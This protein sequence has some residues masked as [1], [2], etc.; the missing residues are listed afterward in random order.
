L[1]VRAAK[2]GCDAETAELIVKGISVSEADPSP[3]F[4]ELLGRRAAVALGARGAATARALV[5]SG[6][7][8][9]TIIGLH[10]LGTSGAPDTTTTL[11][12]FLT[13]GR[14]EDTA[15]DSEDDGLMTSLA[16]AAP[17]GR[18][19][20]TAALLRLAV[21]ESLAAAG[22][23]DALPAIREAVR[24]SEAAGRFDKVVGD[25][26]VETYMILDATRIYQAGLLAALACGDANAAAPLAD[27]LLGNVHVASRS[28][29]GWNA[30]D[31][32]DKA[33]EGSLPYILGWQVRM[34]ELLRRC[35]VERLEPL[36]APLAG[37]T[38]I[39]IVPAA[40]AAFGGRPLPP[41]VKTALGESDVRGV[42]CLGRREAAAAKR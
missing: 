34:H 5:D 9:K 33:T 23:P 35:P 3:A 24:A 21:L 27:A 40:C 1:L 4:A 29:S 2:L 10:L 42:A 38:D 12:R 14:L 11:V 17:P 15:F 18:T 32:A 20:K 39:R 28:R 30:P 36:A 37:M 7:L 6:R 13:S 41:A 8:G 26:G 19:Q 22:D 31:E 16:P 25:Q